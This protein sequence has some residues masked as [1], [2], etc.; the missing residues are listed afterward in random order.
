M[1]DKGDEKGETRSQDEVWNDE[2]TGGA[3][4]REDPES[5]EIKHSLGVPGAP[6]T[7]DTEPSGGKP[8]TVVRH[9]VTYQ[10]P[11][12]APIDHRSDEEVQE[13]KDRFTA[14]VDARDSGDQDQEELQAKK[15]KQDEANLKAQAEAAKAATTP[16]KSADKK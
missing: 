1:A 4:L 11:D 15:Q 16:A 12:G 5:G 14:V 13:E 8:S 3:G 7:T 2:V 10:G 6:T 9:N